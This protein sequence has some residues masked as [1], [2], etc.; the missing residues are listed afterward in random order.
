MG[1]AGLKGWNITLSQAQGTRLQFELES[2]TID[3]AIIQQ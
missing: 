3:H 2:A 1:G